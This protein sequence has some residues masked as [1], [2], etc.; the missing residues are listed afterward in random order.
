MEEIM[1][2]AQSFSEARTL[3]AKR[4]HKV[5]IPIRIGESSIFRFIN[6]EDIEKK[7]N[8]INYIK[9]QKKYESTKNNNNLL[10]N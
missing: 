9:A 8:D 5:W 10:K 3:L 7:Q 4:F 1:I 6:V 2:R